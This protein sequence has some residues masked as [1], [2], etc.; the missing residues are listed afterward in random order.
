MANCGHLVY[1]YRFWYVVPRKIW[2]TWTLAVDH[3]ANA[4]LKSN[5]FLVKTHQSKWI[6]V[7][8]I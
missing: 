4:I 2:Q 5:R 7:E 3:T 6:F 8:K 1:F